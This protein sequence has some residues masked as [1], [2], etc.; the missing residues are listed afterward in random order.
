M[1]MVAGC[2]CQL[3]VLTHGF[4]PAAATQFAVWRAVAL[5]H[6]G[7]PLLLGRRPAHA[8]LPLPPASCSYDKD[9][10]G[11]KAILESWLVAQNLTTLPVFAL[12]VSAGAS[13]A[14]KLPKVTRIN[15]VISGVP[16]CGATKCMQMPWK[17]RAAGAAC[18]VLPSC[19]AA[20]RPCP[21][22]PT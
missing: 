10:W 15:G 1:A 12:G 8:C 3:C 17:P 5:L 16:I 6:W 19:R 7:Q 20:A 21:C 4:L 9:K 11:V 2:G 18:Q 22:N 13:F 14:L